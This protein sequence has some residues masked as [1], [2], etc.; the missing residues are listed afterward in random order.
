M[1]EVV[2]KRLIMKNQ[3]KKQHQNQY[4]RKHGKALLPI[5]KHRK[6]R[7]NQ[8]KSLNN[9]FKRNHNQHQNPRG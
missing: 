2:V 9:P 8:R 1:T 3:R 7:R 5:G 6:K 4:R